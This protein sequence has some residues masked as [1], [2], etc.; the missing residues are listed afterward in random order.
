MNRSNE[1][2]APLTGVAFIVFAIV[3]FALS[4]EPP[5]A[6][7]PVEEIVAFYSDDK[8]S[9]QFGAALVGMAATLLV[10]FFGYLRRVLR[11]AEGEGGVLSAVSFAGAVIVAVGA[12]I[13]STILFALAEAADDVDP[14]AVQALQALWDNDFMPLAVGTQLVL[15]AT[16]LSVVRHGALP[17]WLGWVAIVLGVIA[18]TPIGFAAFLGMAIWILI[19]SILLSMRARSGPAAPAPPAV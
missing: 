19:V 8:D 9:I 3:G 15:L 12:A 7:D 18:V 13:D 4:G 5:T 17:K 11:A 14:V 16:G 10:F 1:W 2:L 6:D